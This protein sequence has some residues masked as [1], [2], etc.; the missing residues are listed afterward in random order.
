MFVGTT[1]YVDSKM[2]SYELLAALMEMYPQLVMKLKKSV[3]DQLHI[4]MD[5]VSMHFENVRAAVTACTTEESARK[6]L[7]KMTDQLEELDS[8]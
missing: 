5:W 1:E 8:K 4:Q 2:V 6:T 3:D 7:A